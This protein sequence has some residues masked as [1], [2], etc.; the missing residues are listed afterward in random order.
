MSTKVTNKAEEYKIKIH[1]AL[2]DLGIS[3]SLVG[4]N[5]IT[6]II[7]GLL[8]NKYKDSD[9]LCYYIYENTAKAFEG[10]TRSSVERG[11]RHSV[12]KCFGKA[13]VSVI[14]K[15]FGNTVDPDTG[16]L[17]NKEFLY[18]LAEYIRVYN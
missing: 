12:E 13:P 4:H 11:I 1:E 7:E 15:Y 3:S 5:Y 9:S 18:T 10:A 16:K 6:H 17:T 2:K 8:T 14:E